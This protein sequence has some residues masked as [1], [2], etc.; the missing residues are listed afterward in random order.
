MSN[1]LLM[2]IAGIAC[3]TFGFFSGHAVANG[4]VGHLA[5]QAKGQAAALYLLAYWSS[6]IGSYGGHF[7]TGYGLAGRDG[8]DRRVLFVGW[9]A[10]LI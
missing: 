6:L 7:W 4:W 3:L 1:S 9:R 2:I 5:L 10:L 8:F